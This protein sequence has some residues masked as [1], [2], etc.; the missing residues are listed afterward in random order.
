MNKVLLIVNTPEFFLSH[1]LPV[2]LGAKKQGFEVH[3]ATGTGEGVN[4]I[5]KQGFIHHSI[6]F[7]RNGQ[8]PFVELL[9]LIQIYRLLVLLRPQLLHL[10]TIKPILYGGI[11]ARLSRV[12]GVVFAVSGLGPAFSGRGLWG[13]L[14]LKLVLSL[15]RVAFKQ[16]R[17]AVIFQNSDD[18][19]ILVEAGIMDS[20]HA[21]MI[22]GS[23]VDLCEYAFRNEPNGK[24][25]I[26]MAARLL[27]DK[28]VLEF[29]EAARLLNHRGMDVIMRLIGSP[30]LGNAATVSYEE[31]GQWESEGVIELTGFRSDIPEQYAQANVVCLPSYYGEGLPKTLIEA[32]ACGRAVITTDHPGCRD[33]IVPGV[34]GLLVP[35]KDS[36]ALADAIQKLIESPEKREQM[37]YAGREYAEQFFSVEAVVQKHMNIYERLISVG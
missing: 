11:A 21:F 29:I 37:G 2:A 8:N 35:V 3:V 13:S 12:P 4:E 34:T 7:T 32:A 27:K 33:A 16:E 36:Y 10:I 14:R 20:K 15:Y 31:L 30:D 28:G 26:V 6:H 23:G 5:V 17:L 9:T 25:V 1:R 19:G 22:P 18:K 24:P